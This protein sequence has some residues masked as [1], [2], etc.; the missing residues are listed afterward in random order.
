LKPESL[1]YYQDETKCERKG[2]IDFIQQSMVSDVNVTTS[3]SQFLKKAS[4]R[5]SLILLGAEEDGALCEMEISSDDE[6][7]IRNW[8]QLL[9]GLSSFL[10]PLLSISSSETIE[11]YIRNAPSVTETTIA[12]SST[13]S[14]KLSNNARLQRFVVSKMAGSSVGQDVLSKAVGQ[15]FQDVIECLTCAIARCS[16]IPSSLSPNPHLPLRC[17]GGCGFGDEGTHLKACFQDRCSLQRW[18]DFQT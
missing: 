18:S 13:A 11:T 2:C 5:Y 7:K 9:S 4:T 14:A 8:H 15:D 12:S 6:T 3:A 10:H 16:F 1:E 17:R